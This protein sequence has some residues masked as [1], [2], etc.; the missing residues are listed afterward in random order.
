MATE[1]LVEDQIEEGRRLL[2]SL[3]LDAFDVVAAFW[4]KTSEEGE[5]SFCIATPM[6]DPAGRKNAYENLN[7]VLRATPDLAISP[8][9]IRIVAADDPIAIDAVKR[10]QE[11]GGNRPVR[12]RGAQ[13]GGV[14]IEEAYIYPT[15]SSSSENRGSGEES[16]EAGFEWFMGDVVRRTAA[17]LGVTDADY[18][19]TDELREEIARRNDDVGKRLE[20]FLDAYRRWL[21]FHRMIKLS[22]RRGAL[23]PCATE[24]LDELVKNKNES[25]QILLDQLRHVGV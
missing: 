23:S 15:V 6:H 8:L 5:W 7:K 18:Y 11:S 2:A 13:L 22:G 16:A 3:F 19:T 1:T 12:C 20:S 9:A 14:F 25:R 21:E 4:L 17:R 10:L 24:K